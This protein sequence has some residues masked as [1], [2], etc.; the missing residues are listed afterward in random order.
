[1]RLNLCGLIAIRFEAAAAYSH[2]GGGGGEAVGV[3]YSGGQR[4]AAHRV[5]RRASLVNGAMY[6]LM[7]WRST[8]GHLRR[9]DT[10]ESG[11]GAPRTRTTSASL[12]P[13]LSLSL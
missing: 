5:L 11:E 7:G 8:Y 12:S 13:S 1:M 6:V 3:R 4:S 10:A 9:F 2:T